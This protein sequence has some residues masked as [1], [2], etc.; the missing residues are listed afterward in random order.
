MTIHAPPRTPELSLSNRPGF[1]GP[2]QV[3]SVRQKNIEHELFPKYPNTRLS[4]SP[5]RS[6]VSSAAG[7]DDRDGGVGGRDF[8]GRR[9]RTAHNLAFR[10][11]CRPAFTS[12][13]RLLPGRWSLHDRFVCGV[14]D[15]SILV[16]E[17]S[18]SLDM[19]CRLD[20]VRPLHPLL[21]AGESLSV[22]IR[23]SALQISSECRVSRRKQL[24]CHACDSQP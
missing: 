7:L 20:C 14:S 5:N 9:R 23:A 15:G 3:L 21:E 2:P 22:S 1:R 10:C 17:P 8:F 6:L 19:G 4:S 13:S 11:C 12:T 16:S 24:P 18:V